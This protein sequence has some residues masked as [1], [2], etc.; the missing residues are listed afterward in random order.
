MPADTGT[1]PE[2]DSTG[3]AS[4]PARRAGTGLRRWASSTPTLLV[5]PALVA[6]AA[7]WAAT[8]HIGSGEVPGLVDPAVRYGAPVV[9]ALLDVASVATV[10]LVLLPRLVPDRGAHAR[11]LFALTRRIS[12][13]TA[14]SWLA[15]SLLLLGLYTAELS[16]GT[17]T[18][19]DVAG[20][21]TG[22]PAGAAL[23]LSAACAAGCAALG[24]TGVVRDARG[25]GADRLTD[26]LGA[27]LALL[28]LLPMPLT[29]HAVDWEYHNLSMV[30]VQLHVLAAAVWAGGLAAITAF[31]A[32]R[33]GLL[34]TTLPRYSKLATGA[35]AL[36][37]V[38]GVFNGITELTAAGVG[39]DGLTGTGYGRIVLL[40]AVLLGLLAALGG[41]ARF[42]LLPLVERH[43]RTAL[44]TWTAVEL[45]VMG[46]A[47]GLGA[48]LARA[49]VLT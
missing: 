34:A 21:V 24:L 33:R 37:A 16:G 11:R 12:V 35:I 22:V 9:R 31:V 26:D 3:R 40:K 17:P 6:A 30:S 38:S 14:L 47:Y 48:V 7:A 29:G 19:E 13:I 44:I 42:R 43:R 4:A 10:G 27:V 5:T 46:V 8:V 45:G 39:L 41:H 49:P 20:Y 1:D 36:V 28:G 2:R 32:P 15:C 23:A 18:A 25:S